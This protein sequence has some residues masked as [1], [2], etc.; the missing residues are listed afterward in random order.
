MTR[1]LLA[2]L[3]VSLMLFM[4]LPVS[5]QLQ[6]STITHERLGCLRT[7]EFPF[8]QATVS[9]EGTPRAYYRRRGAADWCSVDGVRVRNDA[10]FVLPQFP[11]EGELEYYFVTIKDDLVT[12]RSDVIYRTK[13]MEACGTSPA[14]HNAFVITNCAG[15]AA[16]LGTAM[17]AGYTVKQSSQP[18]AVTPALPGQ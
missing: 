5:A 10:T 9:S 6:K 17:G 16:D 13:L 7:A 1:A 11:A 4:S 14:R 12:G 15:S 2:T 8:L 3:Q 18:L